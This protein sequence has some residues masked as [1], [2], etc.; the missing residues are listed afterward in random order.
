VVR[1][2]F[3]HPDPEAW[4]SAFDRAVARVDDQDEDDHTGRAAAMAD[5]AIDVLAVSLLARAQPEQ[6]WV[7]EDLPGFR[8]HVRDALRQ[9]RPAVAAWLGTLDLALWRRNRDGWYEA[10]MARSAAEVLARE[11]DDESDDPLVPPHRLA[12][13]DDEMREIGPGLNALPADVVPHDLPDDHWWWHLPE[14]PS[15]PDDD[16][17]DYSY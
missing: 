15:E 10:S 12:E 7:D 16:G 9:R 2:D 5:A 11:I 6:S 3:P 17:A 8:A 1:Y 14:G 4:I 13:V